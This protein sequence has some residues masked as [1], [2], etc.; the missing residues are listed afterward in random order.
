MEWYLT[1][2]AVFC[3]RNKK[4]ELESVLHLCN[5]EIPHTTGKYKK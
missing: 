1:L 3:K 4:M 5:P 2:P